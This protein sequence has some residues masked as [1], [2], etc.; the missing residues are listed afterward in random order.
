MIKFTTEV[1][2]D[3]I[4]ATE[5]PLGEVELKE[6]AEA[7]GRKHGGEVRLA[8][9]VAYVP[10]LE[11]TA[12]NGAAD[13]PLF[14]VSP[15]VQTR[16]RI[17]QVTPPKNKCSRLLRT[18]RTRLFRKPLWDPSDGTLCKLFWSLRRANAFFAEDSIRK[19]T[20]TLT[21]QGYSVREELLPTRK[22][23]ELR[24][25]QSFLLQGRPVCRII[26]KLSLQGSEATMSVRLVLHR[27]SPDPLSLIFQVAENYCSLSPY[28]L[29]FL[30][31]NH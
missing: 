15:N 1:L 12:V 4:F 30:L 16:M 2:G 24:H 21:R 18:L 13:E 6:R 11:K 8:Q 22:A 9:V 23:N 5:A 31:S 14:R 17:R 26:R 28:E 7:L 10:L 19:S 3:E 20:K 29:R 27:P 25:C